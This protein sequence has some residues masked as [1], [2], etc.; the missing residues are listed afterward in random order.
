MN[1]LFYG[2]MLFMANGCI[3]IL[4]YSFVSLFYL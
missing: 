1:F 3:L 4:I 2:L